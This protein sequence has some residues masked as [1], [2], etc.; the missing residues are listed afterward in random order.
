MFRKLQEEELIGININES[1]LEGIPVHDGEIPEEYK[2]DNN[3][4]KCLNYPYSNDPRCND[5][6][7]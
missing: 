1:W 2:K 3:I 5:F 6:S 7:F 4:V